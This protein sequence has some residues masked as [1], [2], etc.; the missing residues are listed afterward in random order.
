MPPRAQTSDFVV[1]PDDPAIHAQDVQYPGQA[2]TVFGYLARPTSGAAAPGIIVIHE[3]RG[4][5][6]PN[7]DIA[8]RY[9]K[10]GFVAL[11]VDLTSRAGGTTKE[12]STNN[13]IMPLGV[14]WCNSILPGTCF[15]CC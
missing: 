11:A 5:V 3:N 7:M 2:G 15:G 13:M 8:R 9:A 10:E 12:R 1:K 6:E 14:E 4:L